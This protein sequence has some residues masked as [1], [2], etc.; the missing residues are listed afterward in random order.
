MLNQIVVFKLYSI[1]ILYW[2]RA[3]L[4]VLSIYIFADYLSATASRF[5]Q[6]H[7]ATR[8]SCFVMLQVQVQAPCCAKQDGTPQPLI[9]S[10]RSAFNE[11]SPPM[12][13]CEPVAQL[14]LLLQEM[15]RWRVGILVWTSLGNAAVELLGKFN[16]VGIEDY[17]CY[18]CTYIYMYMYIFRI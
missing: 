5:I 3:S 1:N 16:S 13:C 2:Y 10:W 18:L 4:Y 7:S 9:A 6:I 11:Q 17:Y 15:W 14:A 12:H 8:V